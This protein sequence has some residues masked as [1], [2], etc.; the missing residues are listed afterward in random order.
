MLVSAI[1]IAR[2]PLD[3]LAFDEARTQIASNG[4]R[5]WP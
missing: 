1:T 3:E 2:Q 5:F 4:G